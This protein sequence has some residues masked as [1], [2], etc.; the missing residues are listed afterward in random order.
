VVDEEGR[1]REVKKLREESL[2]GE[3]RVSAAG[4]TGA[5]KRGGKRMADYL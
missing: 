5:S 2:F 3:E 4:E 1:E